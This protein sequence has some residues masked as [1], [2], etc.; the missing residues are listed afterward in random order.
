MSQFILDGPWTLGSA[1]SSDQLSK[2]SCR[3]QP[4]TGAA[5]LLPASLLAWPIDDGIDGPIAGLWGIAFWIALTLITVAAPIHVPR[6]PFVSL[7][8]API[9]AVAVLGGPSAAAVVAVL[10]TFEIRELRREVPWWGVLYNHTFVVFPALAAGVVIDAFPGDV[11]VSQQRSSACSSAGTVYF[12]MTES[13]TAIA[14][15]LRDHR[16]FSAVIEANVRSYGLTMVGLTPIAWLMALAYVFIGPLVAFVFALPLYTTRAAYKAVVDIRNMFTQTVRA[17]AS[18]IDARDPSTKKH[19]EHVSGIAVEI[20]QAMNLSESEI[21]QLEWAGLLHDIGKIGIR[22]AVLLKPDRLTREE[23]M[24]MNEHPAKGEEILKD[25]DQL[26]KERPLIRHHHE[27]FNGSGYPDRLIGEEIPLLARVLHVADAFEAMTASRPYRPIPLSPAE[28]L[29]EL[30]RYAG[31]Q[32]D[33]QVVEAFGRTKTANAHASGPDD[34]PGEPER[35][36][37]AGTHPRPG[38][39]GPI[40]GRAVGHPRRGRALARVLRADGGPA[41]ADRTT[42]RGQAAPIEGE[43]WHVLLIAGALRDRGRPPRRRPA[44]QPALRPSALRRP[45]PGRAP[46]A[47]RH[48][49]AHRPGCRPRRPAAR[50][51]LRAVLRPAHGLALAQPL[52]AGPPAGDGGH[53]LERRGHPRQWRVHARLRAG[54]PCRGPHRGG[55]LADL[56]RPPARGAR[57]RL[58]ARARVRWA[59]SCRWPSPS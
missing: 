1:R 37:R 29:E 58:P 19:S 51:A 27:W 25:V 41:P 5:L 53:R 23:R 49:V 6:G 38:R 22:D 33:P 44:Q 7:Y 54:R 32:F 10:G 14:V 39:G 46:P 31:I 47:H 48:A 15:A 35:N 43:R 59:T 18:A 57:A 2:T 8:L 40:A 24:L 13:L 50:A 3:G 56:P 4:L 12:L 16:S 34:E 42:A 52:A 17:L 55:P 28:A 21:E 30:H 45:H 26:A 36:V 9:L 20:G 11:C